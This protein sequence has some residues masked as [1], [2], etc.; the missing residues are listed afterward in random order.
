MVWMGMLYYTHKG[1]YLIFRRGNKGQERNDLQS[2][3]RGLFFAQLG[4]AV[5]TFFVTMELDLLYAWWGLSA[6]TINVARDGLPEE[7]LTFNRKDLRNILGL[8]LGVLI[9]VYFMAVRRLFQ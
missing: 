1:L 7:A 4:F 6:A 5:A 8:T 3:A 2:M 9:L